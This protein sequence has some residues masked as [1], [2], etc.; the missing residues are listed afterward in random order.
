MAAPAK[1]AVR[2]SIP[3]SPY[4][5]R[6][7][8]NA[9]TVRP[10]PRKLT[11]PGRVAVGFSAW[12][13]GGASAATVEPTTTSPASPATADSVKVG[14]DSARAGIAIGADLSAGNLQTGPPSD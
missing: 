14:R 8:V 3:R 1:I 2:G 4:R 10:T 5:R 9:S 13:R 6:T 11:T 12:S 7:T